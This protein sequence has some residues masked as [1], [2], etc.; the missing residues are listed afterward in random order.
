MQCI[1]LMS[2]ENT[3]HRIKFGNKLHRKLKQLE[4][5]FAGDRIHFEVF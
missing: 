3:N 5:G 2:E 1:W 4:I